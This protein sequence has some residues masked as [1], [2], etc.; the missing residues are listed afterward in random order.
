[1]CT[2]GLSGLS[3][4]TPAA[5]PPPPN[6]CRRQYAPTY[7]N[8]P[9]WNTGGRTSSTQKGFCRVSYTEGFFSSGHKF[10]FF[11]WVPRWWR[12]ICYVGCE[13][14][15]G[16]VVT[17][18]SMPGDGREGPCILLRRCG[19]AGDCK[20]ALSKARTSR[21]GSGAKSDGARAKDREVRAWSV[22]RWKLSTSWFTLEMGVVAGAADDDG[23]ELHGGRR[24]DGSWWE[25]VV[26]R[27]PDGGGEEGAT[28]KWL[29]EVPQ[30]NLLRGSAC[31]GPGRQPVWGQART[32]VAHEALAL[33]VPHGPST[34]RMDSACPEQAQ[35]MPETCSS[36]LVQHTR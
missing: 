15:S 25:A 31:L 1:M 6:Q 24:M 4:E 20:V 28:G 26:C 23:H 12:R 18:V 22:P 9:W 35:R 3:C 14:Q 19:V 13:T 2:F 16:V 7:P 11:R 8:P 32:R 36:A 10:F 34:D 27:A 21:S 30:S 5:S 33:V 17:G 29:V